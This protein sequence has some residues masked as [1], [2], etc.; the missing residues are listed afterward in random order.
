MQMFGGVA[1]V[2]LIVT[3]VPAWSRRRDCLQSKLT[4]PTA[5]TAKNQAIL[6]AIS[7]AG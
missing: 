3:F 6:R 5:S 7:I 2:A 4:W 1:W